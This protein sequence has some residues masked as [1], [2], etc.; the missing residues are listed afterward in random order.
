MTRME[1]IRRQYEG[2]SDPLLQGVG[3]A[4]PARPRHRFWCLWLIAVVLVALVFVFLSSRKTVIEAEPAPAPR[5]EPTTQSGPDE[6][7]QAFDSG[8]VD[9]E[10]VRIF[11]EELKKMAR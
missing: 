3:G 1:A 5:S 2:V 9:K 7:D 10:Q 11:V 6:I 8:K 4:G